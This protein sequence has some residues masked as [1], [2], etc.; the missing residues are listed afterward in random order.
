MMLMP[1]VFSPIGIAPYD[2][3]AR[4]A[5]RRFYFDARP[6]RHAMLIDIMLMLMMSPTP[7]IDADHYIL[8]SARC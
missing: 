3:D 8:M 4:C 1:V 7:L 2:V 6:S 5:L